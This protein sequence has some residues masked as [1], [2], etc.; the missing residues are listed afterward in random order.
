MS[1]TKISVLRM[2]YLVY[3]DPFHIISICTKILNKH[4][5]TRNTFYLNT[6]FTTELSTVILNSAVLKG[7]ASERRDFDPEI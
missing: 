7:K 3:K 6:T 4:I 1:R 2:F 5:L